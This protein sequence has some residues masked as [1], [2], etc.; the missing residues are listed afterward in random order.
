MIPLTSSI[1][2]IVCG[3]YSVNYQHHLI[4]YMEKRTYLTMLNETP[5]MI[6]LPEEAYFEGADDM[7]MM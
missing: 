7:I 1:F 4:F 2:Y 5:F 3:L 6:S